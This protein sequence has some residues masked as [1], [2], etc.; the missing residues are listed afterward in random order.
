MDRKRLCLISWR[1]RSDEIGENGAVDNEIGGGACEA[2][3]EV[4]LGG[5]A[6]RRS[7]KGRQEVGDN[8]GEHGAVQLAHGVELSRYPVRVG[9]TCS[10]SEVVERSPSEQA[11]I[12]MEIVPGRGSFLVNM[13]WAFQASHLHGRVP[14]RPRSNRM[15]TTLFDFQRICKISNF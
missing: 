13:G 1:G 11:E 4:N 15:L 14:R 3:R 5:D 2:R 10:R 7:E 6:R 12:A 9:S 8:V